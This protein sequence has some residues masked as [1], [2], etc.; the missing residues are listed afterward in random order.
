M[1]TSSRGPARSGPVRSGPDRSGG[2]LRSCGWIY[3]EVRIKDVTD[4]SPMR[5]EVRQ[6]IG[7]S[8]KGGLLCLNSGRRVTTR[9][10]FRAL[11]VRGGICITKIRQKTT[12]AKSSGFEFNRGA[13]KLF[14]DLR[15]GPARPSHLNSSHR[16]RH[17]GVAA[18]PSLGGCAVGVG[19]AHSLV[20]AKNLIW[21]GV[22]R[23]GAGRWR[24][25][26]SGT[27]RS[28]ERNHPGAS[29]V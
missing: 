17:Q 4:R 25:T 6:N 26:G 18:L 21:R 20:D 2:V 1:Y 5:L 15:A 22:G 27:S 11:H 19:D 13:C 12:P 29:H 23:G 7:E 3:Q 10:R 9:D 16:R 28:I 8:A 24:S 14:C